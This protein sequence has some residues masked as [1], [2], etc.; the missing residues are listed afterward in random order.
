MK[1][2]EAL[3]RGIQNEG[4]TDCFA[5]LG[6]ANMHW[7]GAQSELGM[8]FIYTRHEHAAVAG[9]AAY[10]RSTRKTGFA[11]VTCGPGLTQILTILP[12]A[13]RARI[14][15]VILAG[16]APLKKAWYNQGIDQAPFVE[17]CGAIYVPVHDQTT[18]LEALHKAFA[19]AK[20]RRVPVVLGVPFDLQK[21]NYFG[22]Q[23]HPISTQ[24]YT[25][26][27][28]VSPDQSQIAK[29]AAWINAAR[30][31]VILAGL[32][33]VAA[34]AKPAC[35]ALAE[36]AGA[37]L[38]TTLPAKGLFYDQNYSLGVAGGYASE[39]AKEVFK[40]TDLVIAIGSR[41]ASHAFNGGKLT[42]KAKII[43]LDTD[44]QTHVQGRK[45]ADL[46]VPSDAKLGAE[47]LTKAIENKDGWRSAKMQQR[48]AAALNIPDTST[49]P[50]GFLHPMAVVKTL[51]DVISK[52]CHII[53]TS[54]HCA[55]YVAQMSHHPQDHFTVI[56]D[57]GAIGNG[58]SWALGIAT[59]YPD[60]P[61]VLI[62]GDGSALMHIQELETIARHEMKVLIVVLNDG[63][64]GSEIH[65][66]RADGIS[67][68][69]AVFGR[70]NFAGIAKGFGF[71]GR[72]V[73]DLKTLTGGF[74][75]FHTVKRP[76]LWDVHISDQVAS[77]QI[78]AA[79]RGTRP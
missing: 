55:Y 21:E 2:Y 28:P 16:E 60:R 58:T 68:E 17:A 15:L 62:D 12:I 9:A 29:A 64:Y 63:A 33:A 7:A 49:T 19:T 69:G 3:A 31:P 53:S 74:Q 37:L 18:A 35:V 11:S 76:S 52:D 40:Q 79:H 42:P 1:L 25:A 36:K 6:D 14:P 39:A 46:L 34:E 59:A 26:A 71:E 41:L 23:E 57:F 51:A 8:N 73:T 61:V 32:G 50:D 38:A 5:L 67:E 75:A 56:R 20:E 13:V 24:L 30:K 22:P 47:A 54:G 27:P 10:A 72:T 48:T 44:P 4:V 65:K 70:P 77:P 43:H 45:A 78:M 66:L